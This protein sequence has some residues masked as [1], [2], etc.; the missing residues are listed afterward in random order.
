MPG[1]AAMLM[2]GVLVLVAALWLTRPLWSQTTVVLLRRRRANV[3]AYRSR[4]AEIDAE[5][6]AAA[7]GADAAQAL[8]EEAASRVLRDADSPVDAAE[9]GAARR[10]LLAA[11]LALL[12][13]ALTG[14]AYWQ[15]ENWRTR[16]LIELA[17]R[18]PAAAQQQMLVKMVSDLRA[19]LDTQADDAEGW[20]ML[21]RSL[22]LLDRNAEAVSAYERAL[23]L[24]RAQPNAD[25]LVGAGE[26]RA[27]RRDDRGLQDSRALF[28]QALAIEPNH[29]KALWYAGLAAIQAGD[30]VTA[31]AR[32]SALRRQ[33]LPEDVASIL[34]SQLPLIA[35]RAGQAWAPPVAATAVSLTV[36]VR[37]DPALR[38]Q[39]KPD[40]TLLVFAKA[41]KG[42][43]MPLAVQRI[44]APQLPLTVTL[45][46]SLAMMPAFKL[47]G[48]ERWVITARLTR[49]GGAQAL[50]GDL[51]GRHALGRA[52]AAR[53][54]DVL[55]D[56]RLP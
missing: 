42:P 9:T 21:G 13:L 39:L 24:S 23:E 19:R 35:E 47:S 34:D 51:E 12:L 26:T 49:S 22:Q 37:L 29:P 14:L 18:D 30:A 4:L 15:S 48:F 56:Q 44:S 28:E 5:L 52:D 54:F 11:G 31:L 36:N 3:I 41:E 8:R 25:W 53:P 16:E 20:A 10:P 1:A 33:D 38:A 40:M 55:I 6:A 32:W 7:L 17:A 46:D 2:M 45:D 50:S 43:P 27:L